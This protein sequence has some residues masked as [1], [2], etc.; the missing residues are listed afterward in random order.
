MA[1][2]IAEPK[3]LIRIRRNGMVD[4][5]NYILN[6]LSRDKRC[7]HKC[8]YCNTSFFAVG[9]YSS[10]SYRCDLKGISIDNDKVDN[11]S[12]WRFAR[13]REMIPLERQIYNTWVNRIK[14]N[15]FYITIA[16]CTVIGLIVTILKTLNI[17]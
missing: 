4:P 7:C 12:C 2:V 11:K 13:R 8:V 9:N 17:I 16:S 3:E 15:W 6:K 5:L 1:K 14:R 10:T